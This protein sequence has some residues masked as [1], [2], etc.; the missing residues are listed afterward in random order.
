MSENQTETSPTAD[1]NPLRVTTPSEGETPPVEITPPVEES[2]QIDPEIVGV[3]NQELTDPVKPD[4]KDRGVTGIEWLP[5]DLRG[6]ERLKGFDTPEALARAYMATDPL[7][8][9]PDQ[10]ILPDGI[11]PQLG[12]WAKG[13]KLTQA[14]LDE[15]IKF[16]TGIDE[17][18]TQVKKNVYDAGRKQLFDYW[19]DKKADNMRIAES[20]LSSVPSGKN[21]AKFLRATGEGSNPLVIQF[22]HDVGNYMKEGGYLKNQQVRGKEKD[23]TRARYPTMFTEE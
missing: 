5:E 18:Q 3:L 15:A 22:L 1:P 17:H 9:V 23:P 13:I 4:A 2:P 16:K 20:V 14:Q 21:I 10:Y 12:E 11:P 6:N 8:T 7:Q 19:G